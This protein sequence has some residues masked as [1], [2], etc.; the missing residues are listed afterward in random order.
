MKSGEEGDGFIVN[1]GRFVRGM[2]IT[3]RSGTNNPAS[4]ALFRARG[5]H[6]I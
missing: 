6:D 5:T 4:E 1:P 2:K 3:P